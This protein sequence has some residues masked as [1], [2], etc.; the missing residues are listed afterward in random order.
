[1][2]KLTVTLAVLD[3]TVTK[4]PPRRILTKPMAIC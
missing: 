2:A 3:L 4:R 1:M